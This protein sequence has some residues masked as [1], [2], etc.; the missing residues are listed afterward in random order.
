MNTLQLVLFAGLVHACWLNG[1]AGNTYNQEIDTIFTT[2]PSIPAEFQFPIDDIRNS[3]IFELARNATLSALFATNYSYTTFTEQS[4][5]TSQGKSLK[6]SFDVLRDQLDVFVHVWLTADWKEIDA[7]IKPFYANVKA[8]RDLDAVDGNMDSTRTLV[9]KDK[10]AFSTQL[11]SLATKIA[12]VQSEFSHPAAEELDSNRFWFIPGIDA[13]LPET[14]RTGLENIALLASALSGYLHIEHGNT[15]SL[16]LSAATFDDTHNLTLLQTYHRHLSALDRLATYFPQAWKD[17]DLL[18]ED[19]DVLHQF[20][21]R[22]IGSIIDDMTEYRTRSK[23]WTDIKRQARLDAIEKEWEETKDF[24][25]QLDIEGAMFDMASYVITS[26]QDPPH[27]TSTM[28]I[29]GVVV[30]CVSAVALAAALVG[31]FVVNRGRRAANY[32]Q[33]NE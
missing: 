2:S 11:S 13:K 4:R 28:Q 23:A 14:N 27:R 7:T 22:Y 3:S 5:P 24:Q 21:S 12:K 29:V 19:H 17:Q 8:F 20:T 9:L 6:N 33:L 30:G 18:Q 10:E 32:E 25:E 31:Y 15:M 26:D 16:Q 1:V